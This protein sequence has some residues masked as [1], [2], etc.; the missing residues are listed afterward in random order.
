M[1]RL[2]EAEQNRAI[3]VF[4][5]CLSAVNDVVTLTKVKLL[6]KVCGGVDGW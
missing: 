6:F 1:L 3:G 4:Q 5:A 2:T